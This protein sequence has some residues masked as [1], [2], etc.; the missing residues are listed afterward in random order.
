[1]AKITVGPVVGEVTDT[2]ARILVE[3]DSSVQVTCEAT[4]PNKNVVTQTVSFT[5]DRPSVFKLQGLSPETEYQLAFKGV[6]AGHPKGRV[7]T[8][9]AN[10]DRLNVAAVSC[11]FLGRRGEAN[12]WADLRDR[13]VI[14]GDVDLLLHLG[15]QIYG[16][17]TFARALKI[18]RGKEPKTKAAQ[19]EQILEAYR[20]LYRVWWSEPSTRDVLAN[21]S[22]LM[23]W[24]DHEIRDDWGSRRED[25]DPDSV[26]FRIGTLAR[27]VYREYQR[28]LWEDPPH[29]D[30]EEHFHV[31][32]Q[33]GVLFVDQRGG[34]SFGRDAARPYLGTR[35]WENIV[36][37]LGVGGA[38]SAVRALIVVTSV[39]LVYLGSHITEFGTAAADDL[40]DHWSHPL[41]NKEQVEMIRELRKWKD[42]APGQRELLVVGGDVHVG[43]HTDILHEDETVFKQ[44]ITS[45]IT[46]IP[47][48]WHAFLGLLILTESEQQITGSYSYEHHDFTN[49]R[50]YGIILVRVPPNGAPRVEGTLVRE[51]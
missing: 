1:M 39:P 49:K 15:D 25:S 50:N 28:Q 27:Q 10:A 36:A 33:I 24:D 14:P 4:D 21:V 29:S 48:K 7:R 34:R 12:L 31:W 47:P 37:A 18:I 40:F 44:L 13:Y 35:Q 5:K 20:R 43:G 23:I 45:P 22:N 26:E 17:A 19:D 9:K 2:T 42:A 46:N 3:V 51:P 38:F 41:H 8:F 11:D 30:A 16:D 32:G 6:A